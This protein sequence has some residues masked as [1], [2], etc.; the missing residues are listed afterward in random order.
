ME[1][2]RDHGRTVPDCR[3]FTQVEARYEWN[4]NRKQPLGRRVTTAARWPFGIALT[5]WRYMW[6]TTPMHRSEAAGSTADRAPELPGTLQRAELQLPH[7][8]AGPFFHRRYE[9]R[10]REAQLSAA[11]VIRRVSSDPNCVSPTE[12]ARFHKVLG[13]QGELRAG[14]EFVVR[15]PGPW[16]GPVRV[17]EATDDS[18]RLVTLAG[19]LEAGQIR[20][21]AAEEGDHLCFRIESWA[22]S[23]DRLSNVLYEK[24]RMAKEVQL[25]MWSSFLERVAEL[26]GGRLTGGIGS[27]RAASRTPMRFP[28]IGVGPADVTEATARAAHQAAQLRPATT[29]TGPLEA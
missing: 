12:F 21:T 20:F 1:R 11:E 2:L 14:D 7:D 5:S 17:V 27:S 6:R 24:L 19:H 29:A 26:S 15:M 3:R 18:F 16:D 13:K 9:A 22:R 28:D 4:V 8:G 23:G 25:H 10:I